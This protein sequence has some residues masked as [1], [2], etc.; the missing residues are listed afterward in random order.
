VFG[1]CRGKLVFGLPGNPISTMVTF[2]LFVVPAID[3]LGGA[4]AQPLPLVGARLKHD[5]HEKG[6]L[7]HFV[8]AHL[9]WPA[10]AP[11]PAPSAA[12]GSASGGASGGTD[13]AGA[14]ADQLNA[15]GLFAEPQ[16][17]TLPWQG[18]GDTVAVSRANAFLVVPAEKLDWKAGEWVNV[19]H[20]RSPGGRIS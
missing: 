7:T 16:I 2:E 19:L 13:A 14:S 1:R 17:E 8:P 11:A 15:G 10:H 9:S 6:A 18:S 3:V 4:G 20:R 5:V 12:A